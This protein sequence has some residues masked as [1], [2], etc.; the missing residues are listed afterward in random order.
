[1]PDYKESLKKKKKKKFVAYKT[2][3]LSF[4][5]YPVW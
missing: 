4:H 5:L 2:R 3:S 1:M